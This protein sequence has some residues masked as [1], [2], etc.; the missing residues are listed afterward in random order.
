MNTPSCLNLFQTSVD[1]YHKYITYKICVMYQMHMNNPKG[2]SV[3][4]KQ[5][6]FSM[7]KKSF[8]TV[9]HPVDMTNMITLDKIDNKKVRTKMCLIG[10]KLVFPGQHHV[11]ISLQ[12]NP[13]IIVL[14]LKY[15]SKDFLHVIDRG[16]Y[17]DFC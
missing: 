17:D 2:M 13:F 6:T 16:H 9:T 12:N 10:H 15:Y 14:S 1:Y 4:L 5:N 8:L 3:N 7:N 11:N